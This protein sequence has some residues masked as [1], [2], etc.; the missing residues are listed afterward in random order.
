MVDTN[1][2]NPRGHD[3]VQG[4]ADDDP[5]GTRVGW[6]GRSC[7]LLV[8]DE[9]LGSDGETFLLEDYLRWEKEAGRGSER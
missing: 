3:L 5:P 6:R 2:D 4:V 1:P 9:Y 8:C 7:G